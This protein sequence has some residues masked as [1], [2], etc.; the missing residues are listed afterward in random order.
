MPAESILPSRTPAQSKIPSHTQQNTLTASAS[1][2]RAQ[3]QSPV[4]V[5]DHFKGMFVEG[6]IDERPG[7]FMSDRQ[8]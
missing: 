2:S 5:L 1:G 4:S 8:R 7:D 6:S 3:A